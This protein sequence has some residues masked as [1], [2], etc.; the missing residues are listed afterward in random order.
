MNLAQLQEVLWQNPRRIVFAGELTVAMLSAARDLSQRGLARP[1]IV[2]NPLQV[3]ALAEENKIRLH[4]VSVKKPLHDVHFDAYSRFYR[5]EVNPELNYAAAKE[6][7]Q[8]PLLYAALLIRHGQADLCLTVPPGDVQILWQAEAIFSNEAPFVS[9]AALVYDEATG[10]MSIFADILIQARPDAQGL[11]RIALDSAHTFSKLSGAQAQVALLSFST[12]GS[13]QHPR[14]QTVRDARA[15]LQKENPELKVD[16]ELQFDAAFVPEILHKKAPQ[17]ALSGAANV[18]VFPSL[19]AADPA[20]KIVQTLT[21]STV[22]APILQGLR[23][24]VHYVPENAD[25]E[26]II[27]QVIIASSLLND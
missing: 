6:L 17:S 10:T 7:L 20:L 26:Q 27:R 22:I 11:A 24:P 3:H 1:I 5:K 2:G 16:G 19:N 23:M 9:A 14:V 21:S 15:I 25:S 8:Q 4:G 18:F 13:A 12:K